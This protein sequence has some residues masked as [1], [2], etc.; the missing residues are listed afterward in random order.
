MLWSPVVRNQKTGSK[1]NQIK[2]TQDIA[3]AIKSEYDVEI[4]LVVNK[5]FQN[6]LVTLRDV[7]RK[8]K[9]EM[10]SS[11]MRYL[12]VEEHLRRHLGTIGMKGAIK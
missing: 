5:K 6:A 2:D 10:D 3:D 9:S 12:Q 4:E 1:Y 11:V 8:T 7:A